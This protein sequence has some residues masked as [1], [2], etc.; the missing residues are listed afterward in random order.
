MKKRHIELKKA[1]GANKQMRVRKSGLA[2]MV[3]LLLVLSLFY[4]FGLTSSIFANAEPEP[5]SAGHKVKV[6]TYNIAAGSGTDG[7]FDLD[8]TIAAIRESGADIIGLQEVDVHWGSRSDFVDEVQILAE[9]LDMQS[10]FAP[11]YD[12][13]PAQ[14]GEPR[15]QFG[16]AVLSKYPI[17]EANNHEITRLSTQEPDPEPKPAPGFLEAL[18]DVDGSHLWFYVTHLDARSFRPAR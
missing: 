8:R 13:D 3:S 6:A 7:Q 9:A 1:E 11:I 17:L 12:M 15:R 5:A 2:C 4:P 16:L 10:Y 14:P 18:I